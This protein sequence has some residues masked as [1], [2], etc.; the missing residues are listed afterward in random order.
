LEL[1][2]TTPTIQILRQKYKTADTYPTGEKKKT[3]QQ[4]DQTIKISKEVGLNFKH[5]V[6]IMFAYIIV[7]FAISNQNI[8]EFT[9]PLIIIGGQTNA[10]RTHHLQFFFG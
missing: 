9:E 3:Q 1:G 7:L 4:K 6:T 5:D 2:P 8:N 10:I